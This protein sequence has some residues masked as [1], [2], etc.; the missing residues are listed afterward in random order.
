M[1]EGELVIVPEPIPIFEADKVTEQ[2]ELPTHLD[3]ML[4][5]EGLQDLVCFI[6]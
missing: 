4:Q 3:S 5:P 2:E 1:P 6:S